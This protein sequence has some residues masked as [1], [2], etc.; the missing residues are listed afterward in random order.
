[1]HLQWILEQL[2]TE[3][4]KNERTDMHRKG[5]KMLTK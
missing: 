3:E 4:S 2:R 1:M 5:S